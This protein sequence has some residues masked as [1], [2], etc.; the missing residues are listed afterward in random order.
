MSVV[1]IICLFVFYVHKSLK[2]DTS[3]YAC[4]HLSA[5]ASY[6]TV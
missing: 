3:M 6:G 5:T 2:F 4:S 1:K